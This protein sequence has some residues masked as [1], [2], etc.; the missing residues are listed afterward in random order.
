MAGFYDGEGTISL[1]VKKYSIDIQVIFVQAYKPLLDELRRFLLDNESSLQT[2]MAYKDK[3]KNVYALYVSSNH[4]VS[5]VLTKMLPFLR[6]KRVQAQCVVDYLSDRITGVELVRTFNGEVLAGRRH[7]IIRPLPDE[8]FMHMDGIQTARIR[9][10]PKARDAR[11]R[12][13]PNSDEPGISPHAQVV[14]HDF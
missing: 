13:I 9:S 6:L 14:D 10:H 5:M 2:K 4:D 8:G 1:Y 3:R 12:W 11:G 7:G